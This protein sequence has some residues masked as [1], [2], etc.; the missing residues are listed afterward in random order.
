MFFSVE[1]EAWGTVGRDPLPWGLQ[2]PTPCW[3]LASSSAP[4]VWLVAPADLW[5]RR[6]GSVRPGAGNWGITPWAALSAVLAWAILAD[7]VTSQALPVGCTCP[8]P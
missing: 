4:G 8:S 1:R 7:S 2:L 5:E 3:L 6:P